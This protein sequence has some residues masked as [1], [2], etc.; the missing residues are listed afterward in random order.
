M[1]GG[2]IWTLTCAAR[3]SARFPVCCAYPH[4]ARAKQFG[5]ALGHAVFSTLHYELLDER[6]PDT[7]TLDWVASSAEHVGVNGHSAQRRER[8]VTATSILPRV[9]LE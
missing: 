5:Q 3:G 1:N 7:P 8:A 2:A 4:R 9:A 6:I